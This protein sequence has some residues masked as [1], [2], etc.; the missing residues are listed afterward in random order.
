MTA[1]TPAP[2]AA[3]GAAGRAPALDLLVAS[4]LQEHLLA[5]SNDLERLDTLL[6]DASTTLMERFTG[7]CGRLEALLADARHA[8]LHADHR[9]L[10]DDLAGAVTAL[11]FQDM[12]AQL[13]A[14]THQRLRSCADLLA[15]ETFG[16]DEDGPAL[17]EAPPQR[18]NPV[19][20]AE[21]DAGSIELF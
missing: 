20:Q 13:I 9:P 11:Q 8:A 14:H 17:V 7:S 12:A 18:P 16:A 6:A 19:T 10:L 5:A 4:E 15:R 2:A 21:M 1:Q 3:P